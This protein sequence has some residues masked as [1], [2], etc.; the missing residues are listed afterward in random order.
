MLSL[1]RLI[2]YVKILYKEKSDLKMT[3]GL[4]LS[5]N[6]V[7]WLLIWLVVKVIAKNN[8]PKNFY[9]NVVVTLSRHLLSTSPKYL[10]LGNF[11]LIH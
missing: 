11:Q 2:N 10:L 5:L 4:I 9:Y 8:Y 3:P 7:K 1:F 6:S